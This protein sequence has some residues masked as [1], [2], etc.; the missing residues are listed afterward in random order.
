MCACS[1]L[2]QLPVTQAPGTQAPV[3]TPPMVPLPTAPGVPS[4][5]SADGQ[6]SNPEQAK[7]KTPED[8]LKKPLTKEEKL[9]KLIDKYD[10]MSKVNPARP[11]EETAKPAE[12]KPKPDAR[13]EPAPLPGSVAESNLPET[14]G[15]QGPE[16][17]PDS[18]AAAQTY[19]GPAVL[20]RS[21]TLARPTAAGTKQ[22]QWQWIA[23]SSQGYTTGLVNGAT[24]TSAAST[25][26][27]SYST[28]TGLSVS[29]RHFWK[30]DQVGLNYNVS[31]SAFPWA[32]AYTGVNQTLSSDYA[33]EFSRRLQ[34]HV[35]NTGSI[36]PPSA[37][38]SNPLTAPGVSIAN[39]SLSASPSLQLLDN[40]TEQ[41]Q[42]NST[43]VWQQ[44]ARTSYSVGG[45]FFAVDRTGG[46]LSGN[47]GYQAEADVNYR[48]NSKT[49]VGV[50]YSWTDYAFAHHVSVSDTN[51][52]DIIFSR[53]FGKSTQL[54]TR[55][56][57]S[58]IESLGLT[59]VAIDPV[60]AALVG[61][62]SGIID[63]YH[64]NVTSDISAQFVRD[65]RRGRTLSVSFARGVSPGNG[66]ILTAIQE[67]VTGTFSTTVFRRFPVSFTAGHSALA[68][69][70]QNTGG[71]TST[72]YSVTTSRTLRNRASASFSAQY[73][74]F[75]VS[76]M[77][78]LKQQIS[79]TSSLSWGP[80][81]GK[82]W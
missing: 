10:P 47:I 54:R 41:F 17:V 75:T 69:Q 77:P 53:S 63:A 16:V 64:R 68:S 42:T 28:T 3:T 26:A 67:T 71:Y 24:S 61:M 55:F 76:N 30:R 40:R 5:G 13:T 12:A 49:T 20:S 15:R 58:R 82:L 60:F 31:F 81:P 70:A 19:T 33:H 45:G 1:G 80:G 59:A 21:Y 44:T 73:S 14:S 18:D 35:V 6:A 74:S 27:S 79:L 43:L 50:S 56:G 25:N 51:T 78:G 7:P 46:T 9:Q 4:L 22:V 72:F 23:T 65:L 66:L 39:L 62:P 2:A 38:L 34:L 29:G 52:A 57:L 11:E 48:W 8:K 37:T 36:S 32:S